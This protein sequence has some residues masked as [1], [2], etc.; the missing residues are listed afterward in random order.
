MK[1]AEGSDS[2]LELERRLKAGVDQLRKMTDS[3]EGLVHVADAIGPV[4]GVAR[5]RG[6]GR[7]ASRPAAMAT[8]NQTQE[9]RSAA[10]TPSAKQLQPP[11]AKAAPAQATEEE[12]PEWRKRF[13]GLA[14]EVPHRAEHHKKNK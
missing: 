12:I 14:A 7:P 10:A 2:P 3:L 6:R 5:G 11:P 8:G 4:L 1:N 9:G 13:P